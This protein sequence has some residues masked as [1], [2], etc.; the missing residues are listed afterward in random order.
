MQEN[1]ILIR[2]P[3][4]RIKKES[5]KHFMQDIKIYCV[6]KLHFVTVLLV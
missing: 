4:R 5:K 6:G 3:A 1:K 2:K